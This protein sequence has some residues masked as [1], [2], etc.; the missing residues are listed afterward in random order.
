MWNLF[1]PG[2]GNS[3]KEGPKMNSQ[4]HKITFA[5]IPR[6]LWRGFIHPTHPE[7]FGDIHPSMDHSSSQ[8][9]WLWC[10]KFCPNPNTRSNWI[11]PLFSSNC[12]ALTHSAAM[13][14]VP[15]KLPTEC[16][17]WHGFHNSMHSS[18]HR[19]RQPR[20]R[21]GVCPQR[22]ANSPFG[23]LV[24]SVAVVVNCCWTGG[25]DYIRNRIKVI[26]F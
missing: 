19:R 21:V 13:D 6:E 26:D 10:K 2:C 5:N 11:F 4:T 23:R 14:T 16:V 17:R 9:N 15:S 22:T 7:Q 12:F 24:I 20:W 1:I 18:G 25:C 8:F 3:L